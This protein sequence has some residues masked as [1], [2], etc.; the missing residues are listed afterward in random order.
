MS[1]FSSYIELA[2]EEITVF[3]T[4]DYQPAEPQ[5]HNYPGCGES[6]VIGAVEAFPKKSSTAIDLLP[7]LN[8]QAI[9]LLEEQLIEY[10]A[11][12]YHRKVSHSP[13][14]MQERDEYLRESEKQR[15]VKI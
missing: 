12:Q 10:E 15:G 14:A 6:A 7:L 2:G 8:Q 4:G 11:M 13:L 1:E 5:T 3:V 9:E